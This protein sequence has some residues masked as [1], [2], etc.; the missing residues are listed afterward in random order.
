MVAEGELHAA[1]G[2]YAEV[3]RHGIGIRDGFVSPSRLRGLICCAHLRQARGDFGAAQVGAGR[4]RQQRHEIRGDQT[5][6]L[7]E[8]VFDEERAL[9]GELEQLRLDFNREAYLGLLDLELHYALY[10]CGAGYARHLDQLRGQE[11][12]RVAVILYLNEEWDTAAGGELRV[13]GAV[14]GHCDIEPVGGRLVCFLTAGREHAVLPARRDRWSIS[15][16]FRTR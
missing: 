12:R 3:L 10:A 13:F 4:E 5:C 16:W 15:G 8:P 1:D 2:L 7:S 11:Q 9:L 6:W 14:D